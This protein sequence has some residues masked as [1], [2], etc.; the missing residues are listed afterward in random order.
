MAQQRLHAVVRGQ[1]QMVGFR[2]YTQRCAVQRGVVGY[3]RNTSDGAVEVVAE[4]ERERLE[5]L[6][7]DLRRGPDG[8][9]VEQVDCDWQ[10][11]SGQFR[12]FRI[13]Y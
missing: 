12:S 6:L 13:T 5:G 4:G 9:L 2:A 8:A 11:P 1:V 7:A 3:V 10:P